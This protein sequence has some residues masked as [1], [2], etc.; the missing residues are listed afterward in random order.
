MNVGML[1]L[2]DD[3][4]R[5]FEE[6]IA[7]AAEYYHHKYGRKPT[8]CYVHQTATEESKKIDNI[9]IVPDQMLQKHHFLLGLSSN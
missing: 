5:P 2:D 6:K 4:K 9:S 7:R 1:W 3:K 8:H